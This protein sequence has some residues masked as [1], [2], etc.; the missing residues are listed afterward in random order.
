MHLTLI[1]RMALILRLVP[2]GTG[3]Q[4]RKSNIELLK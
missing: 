2:T 4:L 3:M 1:K